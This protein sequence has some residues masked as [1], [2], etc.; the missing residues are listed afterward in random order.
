M[1]ASTVLSI[2]ID[3]DLLAA[4]REKAQREGRTVSA[5]VLDVVRRAVGDGVKR[6]SPRRSTM[7]MFASFEAPELD[8]LVRARR[9]F[10]RSLL[11]SGRRSPSDG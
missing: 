1:P 4:L 9:Q 10:S 7:G 5:T 8:D 6:S 2:R 3:P 11:S